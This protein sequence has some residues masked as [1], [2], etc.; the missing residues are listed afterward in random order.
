MKSLNQEMTAKT[1]KSNLI[2]GV[3][4]IVFINVMGT[5]FQGKTVA[6]LPF[7]PFGLIQG[8]THRNIE[9]T[10]FTDCSYLFIYILTAFVS[11]TNLKKVLGFEPPT[12]AV[13][14][15]EPPKQP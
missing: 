8:I 3:F 10:D 1:M 15:F 6:K 5:T 9:G 14:F 12:T 11:R 4:M 7:V 2:V 13:S